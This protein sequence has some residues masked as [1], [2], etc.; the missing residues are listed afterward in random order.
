MSIGQFAPKV[1]PYYFVG[2]SSPEK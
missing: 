2:K 1:T